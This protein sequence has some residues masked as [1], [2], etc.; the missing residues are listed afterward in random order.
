MV[1][2]RWT[3][4]Q[5]ENDAL[6]TT[7]GVPEVHSPLCIINVS[8]RSERVKTESVGVIVKLT[9][10]ARSCFTLGPPISGG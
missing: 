1:T 6:R 2:N 9:A 3:Y 10:A 7:P 5:G 4:R 8:L